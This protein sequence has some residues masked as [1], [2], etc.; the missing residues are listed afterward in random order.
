MVNSKQLGAVLILILAGFGSVLSQTAAEL[1]EKYKGHNACNVLFKRQYNIDI[2]KGELKVT[3]HVIDERMYL[4]DKVS[5]TLKDNV[6]YSSFYD[7]VELEAMSLIPKGPDKYKKVPVKDF[8]VNTNA[9]GSVFYDDSKEKVF[10]YT[11]LVKGAKTRL[12][13]TLNLT[14]PN[15]MSPVYMKDY[16]PSERIELSVSFPDEVEIGY[17]V[18]N[19]SED[20][21]SFTKERVGN[22][23]VYTWL[24]TEVDDADFESDGP[25]PR[26][27]LPQVHI[28]LVSHE[29]KEGKVNHVGTVD[30]LHQWYRNLIDDYESNTDETN[31]ELV[32][33]VDSLTQGLTDEVEKVK[34]IYS[35]VQANIK[36]IAFE[37][38]LSGFVPRPAAKVCKRR[39]G[40]CKDMASI[41]KE[42]LDLADIESYLTWIG[43]RSIP[44]RYEDIP[45]PSVDNHMIA[46]YIAPDGEV[47]FLDATDRYNTFG[48][49]ANHIQGKQALVSMS[50]T[51]YKIFEVP[52]MDKAFSMKTDTVWLQIEGDKLVGKGYLVETGY[53]RNYMAYVMSGRTEVQTKKILERKLQKG[54][55]KFRL[56]SYDV[57]TEAEDY[58]KPFEVKYS[59]ELDNYLA[60][61]QDELYV[62]LNLY[63]RIG[64]KIKDDRKIPFDY[65]QCEEEILTFI[66]DIPEGYEVTYIPENYSK[67]LGETNYSINYKHENNQIIYNLTMGIS[68]LLFEEEDFDDW[69][70]IYAKMTKLFNETIVLKQKK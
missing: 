40:D 67:F 53:L 6:G 35:W 55:N 9:S 24:R 23:N 34:A 10:Y 60:S 38:E 51:E 17:R 39:F 27:Y 48:Q 70:E 42:M 1:E 32:A 8:K 49:P 45:T 47:F 54:S 5:S 18:V 21:Y 41:I 59:F 43:T 69:N 2:V 56:N 20:E 11:Q 36:Y 3:K 46:T 22:K 33:I 61:Y 58:Y 16:Y 57:L 12:E 15:L 25:S 29:S 64:T 65:D 63:K 68:T 28:F 30:N 62:D 26:Y 19:M 7:L 44:H 52:I 37:Y 14:Q 66:L 13:Y 50:P 4:N 31:E